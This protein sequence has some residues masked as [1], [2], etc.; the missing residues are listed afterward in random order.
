MKINRRVA[1]LLGTAALGAVSGTL[2]DVATAAAGV[3]T[4]PE[5][6]AIASAVGAILAAGVLLPWGLWHARTAHQDGV[7]L[8]RAQRDTL[9]RQSHVTVTPAVLPFS[10]KAIRRAFGI[11]ADVALGTGESPGPAV[12]PPPGSTRPYLMTMAVVAESPWPVD[13]V[14]DYLNAEFAY[15]R[16]MSDCGI[17]ASTIHVAFLTDEQGPVISVAVHAE[18]PTG[19]DRQEFH[20][21]VHRA[22]ERVLTVMLSCSRHELHESTRYVDTFGDSF[23][24]IPAPLGLDVPGQTIKITVR[25]DLKTPV[26]PGGVWHA[27]DHALH[28]DT[29]V[30]ENRVRS[31]VL[32]LNCEDL[33][34]S[35]RLHLV[36]ICHLPDP[37]ADEAVIGALT[38]SLRRLLNRPL[39]APMTDVLRHIEIEDAYPA[40]SA[41]T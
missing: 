16:T 1:L 12:I 32:R 21:P 8:G 6:L 35:T 10:E 27:V 15:D 3:Q 5:A 37:A 36:A 13:Q 2:A 11:P 19:P 14:R 7:N 38:E 34:G 20:N 39:A 18:C 31:I 41:D 40:K 17:I 26:S 29:M 4:S 9:T 25:A 23:R 33:D 24:P 22:I 28:E 30:L